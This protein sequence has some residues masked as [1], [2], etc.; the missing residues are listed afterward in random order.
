MIE[1]I[2]KLKNLGFIQACLTNNFIPTNEIQPD[3]IDQDK[4]MIF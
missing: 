4:K 3:M 1:A 2:K